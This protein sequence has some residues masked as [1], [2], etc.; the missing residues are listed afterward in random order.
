[1]N[2]ACSVCGN[3]LIGRQRLFCSRTCKATASNLRHQSYYAQQ[4][5]GLMRKRRL[6]ET[7]GGACVRCG[8]ATNLAA[9][10]FHHVHPARKAFNL[11]LRALSNRTWA[12]IEH[13]VQH[14]LVGNKIFCG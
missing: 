10:D 9:L 7:L 1:M 3:P 11:D 12:A 6:V 14:F 8:Y 13:E 5:R 2:P 4:R